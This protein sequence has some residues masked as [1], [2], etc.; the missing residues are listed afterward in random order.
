ML[1][2]IRCRFFWGF[3]EESK[4]IYWVKWRTALA[5]YDQGG[6][7]GLYDGRGRG[8]KSSVWENIRSVG[9]VIDSLDIPFNNSFV[10]KVGC[11]DNTSFW[12]DKWVHSRIPL[13]FQ[14]PRLYAL[15]CSKNC[16]IKD[17]WCLENDIWKGNWD[18]RSYPRG[19]AL[20]ELQSLS[21]LLDGFVLRP[22]AKDG[23]SWALSN[24]GLITVNRLSSIIDS[25]Y[26]SD[27][28]PGKT[29][30]WI[31]LV[32]R[33]INIFIWRL[34]LDR[35]PLLSNLD[36]RGIDVPSVLCPLCGDHPETREHLS[37]MDLVSGSLGNNFPRYGKTIFNGVFYSVLWHIW[38]WRNKVIHSKIE[39][40]QEE[41]K[42][43]I[44]PR[45]QSSSLLC[46]PTDGVRK[47]KS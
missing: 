24:D 34:V 8:L 47:S 28:S 39:E 37:I 17:R 29:H 23:W 44:F 33:K 13:M 35:L 15:E 7:G 40:R 11:G 45:V 36:S 30:D 26:L 25:A 1:E 27:C 5:S 4:G 10:R 43:D 19:H 14:F 42:V 18:W 46:F 3:K 2:S 21:S 12:C 41:L 31:S 38:A 20:S 22:Q 9:A 6:L 32:P 16:L